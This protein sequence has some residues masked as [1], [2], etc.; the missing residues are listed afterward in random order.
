M[1]K[2]IILHLH[3]FYWQT[4]SAQNAHDECQ[5]SYTINQMQHFKNVSNQTKCAQ[6]QRPPF[7]GQSNDKTIYK[8]SHSTHLGREL[9]LC[10]A[11]KSNFDL[12]T[13]EVYRFMP[14]SRGPIVPICIEIGSFVFTS[15]LSEEQTDGRTDGQTIREL[16]Q[17]LGQLL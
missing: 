8:K 1:P 9:Y 16:T 5:Q 6:F 4:L 10:Y 3:P 2:S 15:L 14:L 17:C 13:L 7:L 11:S 12:L